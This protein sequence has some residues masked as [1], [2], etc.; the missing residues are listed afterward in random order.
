[1][2]GKNT[3]QFNFNETVLT[4][5]EKNRNKEWNTLILTSIETSGTLSVYCTNYLQNEE[6]STA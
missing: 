5:R 1:M 6:V 3:F 4:K 2:C